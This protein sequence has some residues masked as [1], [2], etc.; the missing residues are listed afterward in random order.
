MPKTTTPLLVEDFYKTTLT[1]DVN[2]SWDIEL[3]VAT[4]P[5]NKKG[6]IIVNPVSS[7]WRE[8]MYYHDVIGNTIYVKW[9]NR[10]SPKEH[11]ALDVVQINDTSLIFNYLSKSLSTTFFIEQLTSLWV[12]VFWWP[13]LK[14]ISTVSVSDTS[15]T[16]SDWTTNY[17]Y[18]KVSTNEIKTAT[19]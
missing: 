12:K 2:A 15:L 6:F 16:M 19:S 11:K 3:K 7:S 13:V 5:L 14:W 9:V 18:Y 8:R 4:P 17:I 10:I 1:E